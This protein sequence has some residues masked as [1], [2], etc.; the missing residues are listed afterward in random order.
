MKRATDEEKR[1]VFSFIRGPLCPWPFL[2]LSVALS[3]VAL[4]IRGPFLGFIRGPLHP[5]HAATT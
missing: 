4:F 3:S 1:K 2:V 5:L